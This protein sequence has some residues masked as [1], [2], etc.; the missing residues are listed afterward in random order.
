MRNVLF[1]LMVLCITFAGV[2]QAAVITWGTAM[3]LVDETD[4]VTHGILVEAVNTAGSEI[5][6]NPLV[7]GV[8]F[9]G[10]SDVMTGD[11]SATDFYTSGSGD[12]YDILL[13]SLDFNTSPIT[14]GAGTG[15]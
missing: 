7:N 11:H 5:L 10:N 1:I 8:L 4:V 14:V 3:D 9:T 6:L 15:A 12:A 2:S 13:S